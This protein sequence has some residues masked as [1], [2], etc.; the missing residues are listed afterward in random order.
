[1]STS[2]GF[3]MNML[4]ILL[5]GVLTLGATFPAMASPDIQQPQAIE[6]ARKAKL[7]Q[8]KISPEDRCASK[9]LVLPLDHVPRAQSTPYLN[10]LRKVRFEAE[11]KACREAAI[12][13]Q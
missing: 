5:A 1:M 4:L 8:A 13:Q 12:K 7:D 10:Q 11:M 2:K 3:I 9:Q 6:R